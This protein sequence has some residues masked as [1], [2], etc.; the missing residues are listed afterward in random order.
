M[1]FLEGTYAANFKLSFA[2]KNILGNVLEMSLIDLFP[3]TSSLT[4][5]LLLLTCHSL[6]KNAQ[7]LA[8]N[9]LKIINVQQ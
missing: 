9:E 1:L 5:I 4:E 6:R 3:K 8:R 2:L 7:L